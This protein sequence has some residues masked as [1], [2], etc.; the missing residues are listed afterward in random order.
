MRR[1]VGAANKILLFSLR[2]VDLKIS[3]SLHR[4][5]SSRAELPHYL[6]PLRCHLYAIRTFLA[7]YTSIHSTR[8]LMALFK[9][10]EMAHPDGLFGTRR[11][12]RVYNGYFIRV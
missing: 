11:C 3:L 10:L 5:A 6:I 9:A 12:V 4:M 7:R 8:V 1:I 2:F